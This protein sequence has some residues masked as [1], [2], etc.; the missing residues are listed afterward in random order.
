VTAATDVAVQ[1]VAVV[2]A[3]TDV[4]VQSVAVVAAAAGRGVQTSG[5]GGAW[6]GGA[7]Q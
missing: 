5:G 3:A 2:A 1:S 6:Q 4:A 7:F